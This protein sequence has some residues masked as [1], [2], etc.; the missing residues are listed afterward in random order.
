MRLRDAL[1]G[2]LMWQIMKKRS[3]LQ[4]AWLWLAAGMLSGCVPGTRQERQTAMH[5][6]KPPTMLQDAGQ[7]APPVLESAAM[8]QWLRRI[9][10]DP[11]ELLRRKFQ[12]QA[13]RRRFE[14]IQ[15]PN[16]AEQQEN[17]QRTERMSCLRLGH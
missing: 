16:L 4:P 5:Y 14:E 9:P 7:A 13:A 15:N 12:Y 8:Q 17:K 1:I 11:G 6:P 2:E 3:R 10:D